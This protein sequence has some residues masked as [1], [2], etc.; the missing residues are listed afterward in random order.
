MKSPHHSARILTAVFGF[1][2]AAS[3]ACAADAPVASTPAA[4]P[5]FDANSDRG[6]MLTL[7]GLP[8]PPPRAASSDSH[9]EEHALPANSKFPDPLVLKNGQ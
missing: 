5:P 6:R 4:P 8:V 3:L 9:D 7:L 2:Y 1:M